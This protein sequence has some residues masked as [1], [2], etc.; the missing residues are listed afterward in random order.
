ME[1]ELFAGGVWSPTFFGNTKFEVKNISEFSNLQR[2]VDS[3]FFAG[4]VWT[5]KFFG[6]SKF[7]VK[8][9]WEFVHLQS[10]LD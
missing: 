7:K 9:F 8:I 1:S 10:A 2:A 4:G 6:H 5:P 3:E